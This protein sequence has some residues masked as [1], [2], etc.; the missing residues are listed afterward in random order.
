MTKARRL[1]RAITTFRRSNGAATRASTYRR[2]DEVHH[3]R[4]LRTRALLRMLRHAGFTARRAASIEEVVRDAGRLGVS[5][6]VIEQ[7][8]GS[9]VSP[10]GGFRPAKGKFYT[11]IALAEGDGEPEKKAGADAI[12]RLPFDPASFTE[13]V[14][15]ALEKGS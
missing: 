1:T 13:E 5:L 6:I 12:I 2:T 11:L 14:L 15:R 9:G 8:G 7:P 3:V 4:V 10:L